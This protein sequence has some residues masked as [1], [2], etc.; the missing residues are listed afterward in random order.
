MSE[1][2]SDE[3]LI[4]EFAEARAL[5]ER[6][7]GDLIARGLLQGPEHGDRY[8]TL[9]EDSADAILIIDGDT[10]IDCNQATVEMLRYDNKIQLLET[11]PSELSPPVQPDGRDSYEKANEMIR[12]ALEKGSHRFEWDHKRADGE[13]FPVEVL[14]T[15][16]QNGDRTKLHTVWRDITQRKQLESQLRQSQK[17]EAMGRLAG[18]VAHDFNNLLMIING[19]AE[20][21]LLAV[22]DNEEL[23]ET[24]RQIGWAGQRATEL[25]VQLLASSRKQL[26]QPAVLDLNQV[27]TQAHDLLSRL[28]G[29]DIE[30]ITHPAAAP[31]MFKADPGLIEQVI[32][33]LATNARDAM[34]NGGTLNL[35]V[36]EQTIDDSLSTDG[37]QLTPGR[38]ARLTVTDTGMGM[39]DEI[40]ERAFDPFFTTKPVGEGSGLGLSMVY[41]VVQQSGGHITIRSEENAGTTIEI[42]FPTVDETATD[43]VV[44]IDPARGG[45]ETILVVEDDTSVA[46]VIEVMLVE[47]GYT[48]MTSRSGREALEVFAEHGPEIALVLSDVV[49]PHMGGPEFVRKLLKKGPVP[50]VIF[51]SGYTGDLLGSF[52]Q[53]DFEAGFLQ[54][55]F[56]RSTLIRAVRS[57]ID[58]LED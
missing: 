11:H 18:G 19:N 25:T 41:G 8:R 53:L 55:P 43:A 38:Y 42:W 28:I 29:E 50:P 22:G 15:P 36:A 24:V 58:R 13:V 20:K 27:T 51:A 48:V 44:K 33:N 23:V 12:I 3:A 14:L 16:V 4:R 10:F 26:L 32:I 39:V 1:D 34:P 45:N 17:M 2:R 37:L 7:E 49:M 31:V 54:K 6:L 52:D 30:L 9:F 5:V 57:A 35:E 46:A 56:N 21:L 47:A 40:K